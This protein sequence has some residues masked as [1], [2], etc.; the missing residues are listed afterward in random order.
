VSYE[1]FIEQAII[2]GDPQVE[3]ITA[4]LKS[5]TSWV[6][7]YTGRALIEQTWTLTL[8][9]WP[10]SNHYNPTLILP[11]QP[12]IS[13]TSIKSYDAQD[14][15]TVFNPSYYHVD[16]SGDHGRVL[17]RPEYVWP[18]NLRAYMGIVVTYKAG[19]GATGNGSEA[20]IATARAAVPDDIKHAIVL[21]TTHF[22]DHR[23]P[24]TGD[25]LTEAPFSVRALLDSYR[26][27]EVLL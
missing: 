18:S 2:D 1:Q 15:E 6:E 12:L 14:A 7:R 3:R 4:F 21:L 16:T 25:D 20:A 27:A 13:V 5:A 17:L 11:K 9:D 10:W 22:Y 8:D 24:V 26:T 19:Y 23:S